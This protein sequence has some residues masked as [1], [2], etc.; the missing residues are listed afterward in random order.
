MLFLYI[1]N[2]DTELLTLRSVAD[3]VVGDGIDLRAVS[4]SSGLWRDLASGASIICV[5]LLGGKDSFSGGLKILTEMAKARDVPLLC[6]SG[7]TMPDPELTLLSTVPSGMITQAFDY[8]AR[9]GM[10]NYENFVKFVADTASFSG[11]G[12]EPRID[13]NSSKISCPIIW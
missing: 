10:H 6:F 8:L 1:T 5:R 7:E 12:F 4:S 13:S 3:A 2:A 11:I 9:G